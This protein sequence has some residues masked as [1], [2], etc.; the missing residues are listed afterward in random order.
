MSLFY[1]LL[2]LTITLLRPCSSQTLNHMIDVPHLPSSIEYIEVL[3]MKLHHALSVTRD[4]K[5][6]SSYMPLGIIHIGTLTHFDTF[7]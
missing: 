2:S 4:S 5:F 1:S 6:E 7:K 3:M